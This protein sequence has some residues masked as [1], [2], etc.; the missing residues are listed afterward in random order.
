MKKPDPRALPSWSVSGP[1]SSSWPLPKRS[2]YSSNPGSP[3][4]GSKAFSRAEFLISVVTRTLTTAGLTRSI[5]SAKLIG[6]PEG[7]ATAIGLFT[8]EIGF[9]A[10]APG[11]PS[12]APIAVASMRPAATPIRP[13]RT[14]L[15]FFISLSLTA[16]LARAFNRDPRLGTSLRNRKD[17]YD[18]LAVHAREGGSASRHGLLPSGVTLRQ[19]CGGARAFAAGITRLFGHFS[20]SGTV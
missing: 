17:M 5:R 2:S 15:D 1:P 11:A 3:R 13:T 19:S 12:T 7:G 6:A 10:M 8:A 14:V 16:L 20:R 18:P 9:C 4:K